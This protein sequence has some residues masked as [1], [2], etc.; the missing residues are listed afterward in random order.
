M[1]LADYEEEFELSGEENEE[2]LLIENLEI[3]NEAVIW[4][5]DWTTETVVSQLRKGN[6]DLSPKFQRRDAWNDYEKSRFIESLMLGLPV[7]PIIL[8]ERKDERNKYIV[9][10]GKQRLLTLRQFCATRNDDFKVLQLKDL[11]FLRSL[12]R[13]TFNDLENNIEYSKFRTQFENQTIRTIVIKNWPNEKFLYTVFLRLNTGSKK[14]SPQELRQALHP[15]N[16]LDYLDQATGDSQTFMKMLGRNSADPR[17]RD[18]EIALRFFA[19]KYG[20]SKYQGNLKEFLDYTCKN[21]N[22]VWALE[23][24]NLRNDFSNLEEAIL[25]VFDIFGEREAFSR[26][27]NGKFS[28]RF[29]R[30]LFEV[31]SY[32]FS[33]P[34]I[35]AELDNK[36]EEFKSKFI[37]L[38]EQ[39]SRFAEAIGSSTKDLDRTEYR[40]RVI[41]AIL[42]TLIPNMEIPKL[43]LRDHQLTVC[44]ISESR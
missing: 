40:F 4:G 34:K 37:Q 44:S 17:M 7:P 41:Q 28:N 30:A 38:S 6:I 12:N 35:R 43:I 3:F 21:L 1:T 16:F 5:T 36:K 19:F 29:N 10:D 22:D 15:G 18:V 32:Y 27:N 24:D 13:K 39:D 9:I 8:A 20:L 25:F 26:W 11:Q 33:I 42:T 23:S 2:D 14:L 31:Y